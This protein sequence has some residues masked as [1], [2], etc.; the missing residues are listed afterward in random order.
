ME[1]FDLVKTILVGLV[2]IVVI[3][4]IVLRKKRQVKLN[5]ISLGPFSAEIIEENVSVDKIDLQSTPIAGCVG[6]V[7]S[8]PLKIRLQDSNG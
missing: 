6:E 5:S 1:Y 2:A 3:T 8:P 4:L 7:L